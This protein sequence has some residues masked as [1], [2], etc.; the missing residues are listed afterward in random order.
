MIEGGGLVLLREHTHAALLRLVDELEQRSVARLPPERELAERLGTSRTTVRKALD[1]LERDGVIRRQKGR[2]GGAYLTS[3]A[4]GSPSPE[5]AWSVCESRRLLRSL[6]TVKGVPQMLHEQGFRDGTKVISARMTTPSADAARVLG[7]GPV[8]SLLRLR[9]ADGD[10]LSLE[11]MYLSGSICG[12]VLETPLNSVYETLR[13]NL[14]ISVCMADESI[15]LAMVTQPVGSLLGQPAGTPILKLERIG[16]DQ[17]ERPVEY[18]VDLFRADRTRLK[19]RTAT[20][21]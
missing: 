2:A 19:V 1:Q 6:N 16:Y 15:E 5:S 21:L 10:T 17:Q 3:V 18:S 7:D 9:F 13:S 11:Q 12:P 8:V 20:R 14:G 4:P